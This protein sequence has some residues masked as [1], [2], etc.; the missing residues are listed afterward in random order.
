MGKRRDPE[1]I[2]F[3]PEQDHYPRLEDVFSKILAEPDIPTGGVERIEV[4]CL[5][6]GD[7]TYRVWAA[8]AEEA[9]GGYLPGP[10]F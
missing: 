5:A 1:A 10:N 2:R 7:A 8:R 4:T 3:N 6:G 9:E